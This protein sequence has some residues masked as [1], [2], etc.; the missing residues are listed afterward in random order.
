MMLNW[1]YSLNGGS[2]GVAGTLISLSLM[3]ILGFAMTRLTKLMRLPNVTAYILTG[4]IL[5]PY[6]LDAISPSFIQGT[7]FVTDLALAFIA[8]SV[9]EH[10]E[11]RKLKKN[12]MKSAV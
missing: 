9:G 12:G 5:G 1:L 3:L 4:I 8:F 10:F 6:S 7:E 11:F 2:T